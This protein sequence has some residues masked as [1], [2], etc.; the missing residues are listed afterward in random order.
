LLSP[1]SRTLPR[2]GKS[3][4]YFPQNY[5]TCVFRGTARRHASAAKK[6]RLAARKISLIPIAFSSPQDFR[7]ELMFGAA[8]FGEPA[9]SGSRSVGFHIAP[10]RPHSPQ[11]LGTPHKCFNQQRI[12][13]TSRRLAA[14]CDLNTCG[15][16]FFRKQ[17]RVGNPDLPS[18]CRKAPEVCRKTWQLKVNPPDH[19]A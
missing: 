6:P 12:F 13:D 19:A 1:A 15:G 16:A 7:I 9:L 11:R 2:D 18:V 4:E 14:P 8:R 17:R 10:R 3:A 5:G